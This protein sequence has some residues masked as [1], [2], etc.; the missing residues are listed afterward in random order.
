[1]RCLFVTILL[2]ISFNIFSSGISLKESVFLLEPE[3]IWLSDIINGSIKDK[4]IILVEK[5][6]KP[7]YKITTEQIAEHLS[8]NGIYDIT[9][10]GK[11]SIVYI[12]KKTEDIITNSDSASTDKKNP[13]EKLEE[14]LSTY[15]DSK[16]LTI[17]IAIKKTE[18]SIDV[19]K[20]NP[21]YGGELRK[22]LS[23]L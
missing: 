22:N 18:P 20:N 10:F 12:R 14:F 13:I 2:I 6:D 5:V 9:I 11:Q 17:K 21:S 1:M 16:L 19:E 23:G 15:I 7:N 8:E 4:D 3:K